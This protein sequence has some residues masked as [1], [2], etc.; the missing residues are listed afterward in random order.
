LRV[1]ATAGQLFE[2]ASHLQRRGN[3]ERALAILEALENDPIP[4]IRR[5]ARYRQALV[6]E[7][8]G[9]DREAAVLL[10]QVLDEK[11][12]AGA[13]RLKLASLLR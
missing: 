10:R 3:V 11:P 9:R 5:E 12:D 7:A 13:V 6:L 4:E 1:K 2:L 8:N